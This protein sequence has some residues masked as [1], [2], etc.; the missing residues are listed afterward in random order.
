VK[1]PT[2]LAGTDPLGERLPQLLVQYLRLSKV[3]RCRVVLCAVVCVV[4]GG[5]RV[6]V[7]GVSR[8]RQEGTACVRERAHTQVEA[9]LLP[10]DAGHGLG[11][12]RALPQA[13]LPDALHVHRPPAAAA[14]TTTPRQ[15]L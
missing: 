11:F 10:R 1:D 13:L 4:C 7:C 9:H 5:V 3:E 14:T 8:C 2:R 6:R 12:A 15:H